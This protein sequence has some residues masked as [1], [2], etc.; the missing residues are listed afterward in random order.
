MTQQPNYAPWGTQSR[1]RLLAGVGLIAGLFLLI[2]G[3]VT[4]MNRGHGGVV[5]LVVGGLVLAFWGVVLPLA[6]RVRKV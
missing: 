5:L 6:K 4:T 2:A 3:I 1:M